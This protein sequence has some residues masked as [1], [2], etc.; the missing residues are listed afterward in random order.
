[1]GQTHSILIMRHPETVANTSR[2]LSGRENV[3]LS[4]KGCQQRL[5]AIEALV[6]ARP[7]RIWSSPLDRCTTIAKAA[8]EQLHMDYEVHENL[9]ELEFGSVQNVAYDKVAELG[10]PFP[11]HLDEAGHS[12]PAPGAESF[13]HLRSRAHALLEELLPLSGLTACITHG[14]FTRGLLGEMYQMPLETFW[15]MSIANVSTQILTCNGGVFRLVALG[16]SPQELKARA[17]LGTLVGHD[18]TQTISGVI[19]HENCN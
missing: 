4:D 14:G 6:A 9:I 18:T 3:E 7:D 19:T 12:L 2:F 11:W 8:A 15:N 5:Q 13:E 16:L 10:Y 17:T 1:M